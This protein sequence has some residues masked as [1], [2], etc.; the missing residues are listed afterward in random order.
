MK[1]MCRKTW[2][3]I[4]QHITSALTFHSVIFPST[5]KDESLLLLL[6]HEWRHSIMVVAS[7][8]YPPH[9]THM[10]WGLS[11]VIFILVVRCMV[12]E[13]NNNP[14]CG[15]KNN[16]RT[17]QKQCVRGRREAERRRGGGAREQAAGFAPFGK[18][19]S[20]VCLTVLKQ[21][22]LLC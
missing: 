14:A 13:S 3:R 19:R 2:S 21:H 16:N 4:L 12:R 5:V 17:S 18:K 9:R 20:A 7:M 15:N 6:L 11:S 1:Y 22:H 10:R 8:K